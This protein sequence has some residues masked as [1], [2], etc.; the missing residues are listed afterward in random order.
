[1][2]QL[3]Q[4]VLN[5]ITQRIVE[6]LRPERVY[7]LGS[8]AYGVPRSDSD[9]DLAVV[10]PRGVEPQHEDH[11]RAL[12]AVGSIGCDVDVLVYAADRFDQ[13]SG[14]RANMEHTVRNEGRL[15][16]GVD[17]MNFC[18]EWLNKGMGDYIAA[19]RLMQGSSPLLGQAAFH[20]QQS[21]EKALKAYLVQHN[22]PFEK[23][24]D[25]RILCD[26]C[27]RIEAAFKELSARAGTLTPYA[28]QFRY[29]G[30][31]EATAQQVAEAYDTARAIWD[32][33][34]DQLPQSLKDEFGPHL[35]S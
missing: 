1:M 3:T 9:L 25:L 13:R 21:A 2:V 26:A 23:T 31:P 16:F 10:L 33:V 15:L 19:E 29:P 17:G 22:E 6:E 7:L 27:G 28:V 12:R 24:H 4:E 35:G 34:L 18:R 14:W 20:L 11:V 32:F 8:R 30:D 5:A